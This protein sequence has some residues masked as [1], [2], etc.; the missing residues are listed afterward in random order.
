MR[1]IS[2]ILADGYDTTNTSLKPLM[3]LAKMDIHQTAEFL[4]VSK[5]TLYRWEQT[6]RP[7]P[8][9]SKL[10]AIRA[11]FVPWENWRGW[12]MHAGRLF[13]PG[14]LRHGLTASMIE[15]M[16]IVRQY[17]DT[18][19]AENKKLRAEIDEIRGR[20]K[21]PVLRLVK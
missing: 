17:K 10:M 16:V 14:Q 19:E 20:Q 6:G 4:H 9:A 21:A 18:L 5:K 7:D 3:M 12:E 1:S 11:G 13:A 8:T 15:G 2:Q